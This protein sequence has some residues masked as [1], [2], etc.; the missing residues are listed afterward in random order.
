ML[1]RYNSLNAPL[2]GSGIGYTMG[3]CHGKLASVLLALACAVASPEQTPRLVVQSGHSSRIQAIDYSHDGR[4]LASGSSDR[5]VILWD[6]IRA[7]EIR[8]YAGH[9]QAINAVKF[10][11]DGRTLASA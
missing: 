1:L 7:C 9:D 8:T 3:T 5:T 11:P 2:G 10:S 4:L 6:V